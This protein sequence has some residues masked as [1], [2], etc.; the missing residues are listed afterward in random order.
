MIR[1]DCLRDLEPFGIIPLT[2]E[3]DA[4]SFRI[5][6]DLTV[7]GCG[8]VREAFGMESDAGFAENWNS[9]G[10]KS[11]MLSNDI[12]P[13]L[14]IIALYQRGLT[15]VVVSHERNDKYV[16]TGVI[17]LEKDEKLIRPTDHYEL[18][19]VKLSEQELH[20]LRGDDFYAAKRVEDTPWQICSDARSGDAI[21]WPE[22]AYGEIIRVIEQKNEQRHPVQ[23][24]D[25]HDIQPVVGTRNVHAFTGRVT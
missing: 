8:I 22:F 14:A 18:R 3:A 2:G 7:Q 17:G 19:G 25:G 11:I 5:L 12:V 21:D 24:S 13:T 1:I 4:L 6:C 16:G 15:V 10:V 9:S 20:D 23:G